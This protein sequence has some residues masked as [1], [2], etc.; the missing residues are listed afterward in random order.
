M[1]SSRF[2]SGSSVL[3][4]CFSFGAALAL[5]VVSLSAQVKPLRHAVEHVEVSFALQGNSNYLEF[6]E[7]GTSPFVGPIYPQNVGGAGSGTWSLPAPYGCWLEPGKTYIMHLAESSSTWTQTDV[8]ISAPAGY[9][10]YV[11]GTPRSNFRAT[12]LVGVT[13]HYYAFISILPNDGSLYLK[14]GQATRPRTGEFFWAAGLGVGSDGHPSGS[15]QL[16]QGNFTWAFDPTSLVCAS[17]TGEVDARYNS[18]V[19]AQVLAPQAFVN[20]SGAT[21]NYTLDFYDPSVVTGDS[22]GFYTFSGSPFVSYNFVNTSG[23]LVITESGDTTGTWTLHSTLTGMT[24][25]ETSSA[26]TITSSSTTPVSGQRTETVTVADGSGNAR[27]TTRVYQVM[28]YGDEEIISETADPDNAALTTTY[29]YY[30]NGDPTA[31]IRRLKSVTRPDG[32]WEKYTYYGDHSGG[33][34]TDLAK[35]GQLKAIYRPWQDSPSTVGSAT[36]SNCQVTFYDYSSQYGG[37]NCVL[38]SQETRTLSYTTALTTF[39]EYFGD[40]TLEYDTG[41]RAYWEPVRT[42]TIHSFTSSGTYL[43]TVRKVYSGDGDLNHPGHL[44]MQENPDGTKVVG[45]F[46]PGTYVWY[47]P[48][49]V[50]S[51]DGAYWGHS[52]YYGWKTQIDPSA[53][54]FTGIHGYQVDTIYLMPKRSTRTLEIIEGNNVNG[55]YIAKITQIFDSGD[56]TIDSNWKTLS[57]DKTTTQGSRLLQSSSSNG[58]LESHAWGVDTKTSDTANDGSSVSYTY[59]DLNRLT[60]SAKASVA[61]SG[62]YQAQG[63]LYTHYQYNAANDLIWQRTNT[64]SSPSTAGLTTTNT[65]DLAGRLTSS[66]DVSGLTTTYEY[67]NNGLTVK[68]TL[69]GGA[70]KF[71]DHYLDGSVKCIRGTAVVSEYHATTVD[72]GTGALTATVY[73]LRPSD[74]SVPTSAPRW[75]NVTADWAGRKLTEQKPTS[76]GT[77]TRSYYYNSIGQPTKV[78]EPDIADSLTEY[79]AFGEAYRTGLDLNANGSLDLASD[80]VVETNLTNDYQSSHWWRISTTL[81]YNQASS[82]TPYTSSVSKVRYNEFNSFSGTLQQDSYATDVFGNTTRHTVDVDRTNKLVTDTT[83]VPDSST[84]VV[85]VTYNGLQVKQ[86]SAQNLTTYFHYDGL[87][88]PTETVDPRIGTITTAYAASGTGSVGKVATVTDAASN[89]TIYSYDAMTGLLTSTANA[90]GKLSYQSYNARGQVVR[91][92]GQTTYP[93]EYGF[94]DYGQQ[95]TMSTFRGGTGWDGSSWPGSPGTA[96]TTTW[97][98]DNATGTL[99]SKTDAKSHAV[100]YTYNTRGQLATRTWARGAVTTYSYSSTTAEQTGI[101]YSDST[102]SITYT[103]NRMGQTAT[104]AD[105]TG[106][107]TFA[108]DTT[109]TALDSET[110]PSYFDSR[111]LARQYD[112][113]SP[114]AGTHGRNIGYTLSGASGSGTDNGVG[115]DYDGSGRFNSLSVPSGPA[116]TY[117][118]TSNSNLV[119]SISET[120]GWTETNTY[121]AHRNLLTQIKGQFSTPVKAQFDYAHDALG[122]RASV[123]DSGEMF[124]RYVN[125]GLVTIYGYN[126]RSEVTGAQSY[127]GT[128]TANL[129][130]P[131]AARGF[132]Y[133]FDNIGSRTSS[134]V[135]GTDESDVHTTT[136]ANDEVNQMTVRS[137]PGTVEVDGLAPTGATVTV[138][139]LATT[140]QGDFFYKNIAAGSTPAWLTANVAN[141][142]GGSESRYSFVPP[143]TETHSYDDDGNL[144]SDGR[145]TYIWDAENRLVSMTTVSG[146]YSIGVPRQVIEFKYDYLGRRVRKT[147]AN[148][149]GSSYVASLDRKFIYNGW[150]LIA[151]YNV[152]APLSLVTSYA[153][154]LDLSGNL[155]DGGGVGGLLAIQDIANS[156]WHLPYY[157]ANGNLN[158][159]VNRSSGTVTAAYEYSPY[160]ET[161]R[162]TGT[163]AAANLFRFSTKYT[164]TETQFIYYGYR[165]YHPSLGRWLG[166]DPIEEKGG[167]NLYAFCRNN[168]VNAYDALGQYEINDIYGGV[169][170][171]DVFENL[172]P[173]FIKMDGGW[174]DPA[175]DRLNIFREGD[176]PS[177]STGGYNPDGIQAPSLGELVMEADDAA[178]A[179]WRQSNQNITDAF[180][181]SF[182]APQLRGGG[183]GTPIK[184]PSGKGTIG[185]LQYQGADGYWY[186]SD[187]KQRVIPTDNGGK[188]TVGEF[189]SAA[190]SGAGHGLYGATIGAATDSFNDGANQMANA[191]I[192]GQDGDPVLAALNTAAAAGNVANLAL[193]ATGIEEGLGALRNLTTGAVKTIDPALVRFS[194]KTIGA[195]FKEGGRVDGLARALR[196]AGG[197]DLASRIPPIRL[198]NRNGVL[199]TL[200]NRRL[201]AFSGSGQQISYRMATSQEIAKEWLKKFTTTVRQGSGKYITVREGL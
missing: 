176:D 59:D 188:L 121:E 69:P 111:I 117:S 164:D 156:A 62:S 150:N 64:S 35:W 193:T 178:N 14:P 130:Y 70:T 79:N 61:A 112:P 114:S 52:L 73:I 113:A 98:Y 76:A 31:S 195:T 107:R 30:D 18:G 190:A 81:G 104:V 174:Y 24:I 40:R 118:F 159:L 166:R 5:G 141:S 171:D 115:Y 160:G 19:L 163:Y 131:V 71:T 88:R 139:T 185:R 192:A 9:Q 86:Q 92:W 13:D 168:A 72:S 94:D 119:A 147:V 78:T 49:W 33:T 17:L 53:V 189:L 120:S 151:E 95:T 85:V 43:T 25:T 21:N 39:G 129:S 123:V 108:Y 22:G 140:R 142:L 200:D 4:W 158:A 127:F 60:R 91:T 28:G 74:V 173:T 8:Q 10:V 41:N 136:Y 106:T 15:I 198:V 84:D 162:A 34:W 67:P 87:G 148:W 155:V 179:A 194:Q 66:T 99:T 110:F 16:S 196:G 135:I 65:Y 145:W 77:F 37:L 184:T 177:Y 80:R 44:V 161:L 201:A 12:P 93:V 116:F 133:A 89:T 32:S 3:R 63:T 51:G 42:S 75:S 186:Y 82:S 143:A 175:T 38:S 26:R 2:L 96:D 1:N 57:V 83:D 109:T 29:E 183:T 181:A 7:V 58:Y 50:P 101:S 191:V 199:Y 167:L 54:A 45:F 146:A 197:R 23:D 36:D 11:G 126:D 97:A 105:V 47:T 180:D 90:M 165:Y 56:P 138:N 103:Y 6:Y 125:S 172:H 144:L 122:R 68:I 154:G 102:P 128:N 187:N 157:D 170:D 27:K 20:V 137:G 182:S 153:W 169:P 55:T 152:G 48:S 124:A 100:S 132:S 46:S 149:S 134:S